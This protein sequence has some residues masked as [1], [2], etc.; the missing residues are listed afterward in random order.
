M[1]L[2][3]LLRSRSTRAPLAAAGVSFLFFSVFFAPARARA[4][5]GYAP[6]PPPPP[7]P[8]PP[9]A[10][11]YYRESRPAE[12]AESPSGL[13]LGLDVEAAVPVNAPQLANGNTLGGGDGIKFRIGDQL[14]ISPGFRFTPELGY[15][16]DH[17]FATDTIGN[18]YS[19]DMN[20]MFFGARIAFGRFLVP[21]F[22][23]HVGYGWRTTGDPSVQAA[24]GVAFDLGGALDVR[25]FR[26]IQL[27][28]HAEWATIDAQ[29]YAP[30]WVAIGLHA[31][32]AF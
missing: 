23:G 1:A 21:S 22:Y 2:L 10:T 28:V 26:M 32:L 25:L 20:R 3:T 15:G 9:P 11:Y 8:P 18:A 14:R 5:P 13:A 7:P 12:P 29:P 31:D 24:D 16:Y 27:G 30:E 4:Q 17:L 19:W 6:Y